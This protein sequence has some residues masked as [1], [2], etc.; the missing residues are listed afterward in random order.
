MHV[1]LKKGIIVAD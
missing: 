1:S